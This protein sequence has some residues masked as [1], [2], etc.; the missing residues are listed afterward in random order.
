[1]D[2]QKSR[3][4]E[5]LVAIRRRWSRRAGA[6]VVLGTGMGGIA[7]RM[8]AEAV[9]PY[10]DVPGIPRSTAP[11]HRGRF[12]CGTLSD[13]PVV[14][15][16]GRVH[17]Y[18]GHCLETVTLPVRV[19]YE[20]GA[21]VVVLTSA[22]GG[23]NPAYESGQLVVVEDH[24]NLLWGSPLAAK[25]PAAWPSSW[26]GSRPFYDPQL[27]DCALE[28]ARR[29]GLVAHRGV[30][31]AMTGPTYETRAEYRFLRQIGGDVV[32]MSSVP[33]ALVAADCGASVL[34]IS[35]VTNVAQPDAP[36]KVSA[37]DVV[38]TAASAAD[39]VAS[40]VCGVLTEHLA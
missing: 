28:I 17:V 16:D 12:V 4:D 22:A 30:Y 10:A 9:I 34:A 20:L 19:L 2:C 1:M 3:I 38:E 6:A 31:V 36:Q 24:I 40:L 29:E 7:E 11:G 32:G 14:L 15:M 21:R 5:A 33:E 27:I 8:V 35:T 26:R 23:M 18:E 37:D 13:V 39:R 25:K